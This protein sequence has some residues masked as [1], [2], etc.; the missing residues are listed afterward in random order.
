[1]HFVQQFNHDRFDRR[2]KEI[3]LRHALFL[4][5]DGLI[6]HHLQTVKLLLTTGD[7]RLYLGEHQRIAAALSNISI[8][9]M[10]AVHDYDEPLLAALGF[11]VAYLQAQPFTTEPPE[12]SKKPYDPWAVLNGGYDPLGPDDRYM[13]YDPLENV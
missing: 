6:T 2:A 1:M 13:Q 3:H 12:R 5:P 4:E 8:P 10:H 9:E 7:K 11:A